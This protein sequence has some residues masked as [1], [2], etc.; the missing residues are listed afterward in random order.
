MPSSTSSSDPT[1][2]W[3]RVGLQTAI[4]GVF[5]FGSVSVAFQLLVNTLRGGDDRVTSQVR[6]LPELV[7]EHR[8]KKK[9]IVFGSSMV[10]AGF[11]P[12]LFDRTTAERGIDSVS[13]NYGM[14]GLNPEFQEIFTRRIQEAFQA[15]GKRLDLALVEFNPF[16]ATMARKT[17]SMPS[18]DQNVAA[19]SSNRELWDIALRDPTKG[20]RLFN[21]RYL[22]AGLSAELITTELTSGVIQGRTRSEVYRAARRRNHKLEAQF[23]EGLRRDVPDYDRAQW[24]RTL[25]GGSGDKTR[26]SEETL[27]MLKE[28]TASSRHPELLEV[29]LQ[30]RIAGADIID[31]GFDQE[32]IDA[33]TRMVKNFQAISDHVE[34][35]LLPR[36]TDWVN[37]TSETRARLDAVLKEIAQQTNVVV[38]DYQ[39]H[40]MIGPEQFIDT[41]HLSPYDGIDIFTKILAEDYAED[42]R[43]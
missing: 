38:K 43:N 17:R 20:A 19:L 22:R 27:E 30:Y 1:K 28:W 18:S 5:L 31:L 29:A 11:E 21:I 2:R 34:V 8:E 4:A 14:G 13:Y 3:L 9:V 23:L 40:P 33:F 32:L 35:L 7:S 24:D 36:N 42:L 41:D 39:T 6:F 12:T 37:Y 10:Q 25:R 26:L 16:Q 15:A